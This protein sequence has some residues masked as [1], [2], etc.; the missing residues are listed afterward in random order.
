MNHTYSIRIMHY[1]TKQWT[2]VTH[3]ITS[4]SEDNIKKQ[5]ELDYKQPVLVVKIS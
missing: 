4:D 1:K 5:F 2:H 3:I